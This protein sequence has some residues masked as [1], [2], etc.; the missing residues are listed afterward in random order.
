MRIK[1][2]VI[3]V[4]LCVF[5]SIFGQEK[6]PNFGKIEKADLTMC[7]YAG[8]PAA[9]A[10]LL[11]DN[12]SSKFVLNSERKFQIVYKRHCKIKIFKKTA[13]HVSTIAIRLNHNGNAKERLTAI[14]AVTFNLVD[15][16]IVKTKLDKGAIF[17][18]EI[19][20]ITIKKFAFPEVKEGCIIEFSYTI[21]SD[22]LYN[23]RGW[24]FQHRYPALW[25]QYTFQIPEYFEYR[26][27]LKG[28]LPFDVNKTTSRDEQFTIHYDAEIDAVGRI[29]AQNFTHKAQTTETIMA[30]KN[31]PAFIAEPDIDC[32][33]NYIQSIGFELSSIQF[34]DELR[35]DYTRTWESV[36]QEMNNE[37]DFGRLLRSG[38]FIN[39]TVKSICAQTSGI[40]KAI[41]LYN[42]IQKRIQW[43]GNYS[44]WPTKG[45]A[46]PFSER[47]GNSSEI[48][49]LLTLMLKTA[50]FKANPV[51]FST[52]DNG[53]ANSFFPTITKFNSVLV[54][55]EID[56]KYFLLDATSRHGPFGLLPPN[57]INGEGRIV[58]DSIGGWVDLNP[59]G[60]YKETKSYRLNIGTD[61]KF[62]GSIIG[63][64]E[65]YAGILK[66]T[67]IDHE[68][69]NDDFIRKMQENT[70]GLFI[71]S[72]S[73]TNKN[74]YA[75]P[76]IDTLNV[77]ISDRSEL[78]GD[79]ILF[80]PLLF[81]AIDKNRY[82]LEDRKY[83]VDYNYPISE[84]YL[85]EYIP[86]QGYQI[87]SLP[88]S[89]TL[90]LADT[91]ISFSYTSIKVDNKI[92]IEYK[93]NIA[94]MQFLPKEYKK[95]K[96]IYNQMVRKHAEQVILKKSK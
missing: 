35:K 28:Y 59:V 76:L 94:K 30:I 43:N 60:K 95:L 15:G 77:K 93:R 51:L 44:I 67:I 34:P 26:Q 57:D 16:K 22:F 27:S 25:S 41:A 31:V 63:R 61:G 55:A 49:L 88:Q 37:E 50:G 56:D 85:F 73:I 10:L 24:E 5:S 52:R 91:S 7:R 71:E 9:D 87:E 46:K 21:T 32:E 65:G 23:F 45:L 53:V 39:D 80:T 86:P 42:Y 17:T 72:Y 18:E 36:N 81:E 82:T 11:F 58:N 69:N 66:R 78:I 68:K 6:D 20:N 2:S 79:K 75:R 38:R 4:L 3:P 12:G 48:N 90:M 14:D 84:T 29:P 47:S 33:D 54:Y 64:Y 62:T 8:D 13:F 19:K 96:E 70:N 1:I 74:A 83:P 92:K 40:E 89:V